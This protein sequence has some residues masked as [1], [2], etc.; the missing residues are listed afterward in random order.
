MNPKYTLIKLPNHPEALLDYQVAEVYQVE[1]NNVWHAVASNPGKFP[2]DFCFKLT[3]EEIQA[4]KENKFYAD[5]LVLNKEVPPLAFT[6]PGCNMLS[7][8]LDGDV[9]DER[10]SSILRQFNFYKLRHILNQIF[11]RELPPDADESHKFPPI[12][13]VAKNIDAFLSELTNLLIKYDLGLTGIP[14]LY[15]LE[16]EAE[17]GDYDRKCYL[18]DHDQI[19]FV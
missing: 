13:Q 19:S 1:A 18:D 2:P 3:C 10:A 6:W 7:M 17:Y 12:K 15:Q 4:L 14:L 8:L 16:A 9:A 11:G 5:R